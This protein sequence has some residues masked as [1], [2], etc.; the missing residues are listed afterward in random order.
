MAQ[1]VQLTGRLVDMTP[2]ELTTDAYAEECRAIAQE[3]GVQMTEIVGEELK[4]KGYGGI[5]GVG[6]AATCPPR[7]IILEY[8]PADTTPT[9]NV[10]LVGKAIVYDTGGLSLKPK[11]GMCGSKSL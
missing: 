1:G 3:L 7:L 11:V 6:K 8:N 9:E 4:E 10:A 2:E 5:Y